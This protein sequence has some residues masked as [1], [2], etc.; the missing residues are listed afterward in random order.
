MTRD[1]ILK[2]VYPYKD[3]TPVSV[4]HN[5]ITCGDYFKDDVAGQAMHNAAA[6]E[7][8]TDAAIADEILAAWKFNTPPARADL[9]AA[10][11]AFRQR[12]RE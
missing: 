10:A 5:W 12:E 3:E 11:K 8:W 6:F 1:R 2:C 7:C 9:I 4:V